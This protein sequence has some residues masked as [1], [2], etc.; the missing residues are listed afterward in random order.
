MDTYTI[1]SKTIFY[2]GVNLYENL[3]VQELRIELSKRGVN[4]T[5]KKKPQLETDLE[6]L[7]RGVTNV[8]ALLQNTPETPLDSL[9]LHN[10]EIS[11]TEPLHDI[12]GHLSNVADELLAQTTGNIKKKLSS[13]YESVLGKETLRCC[14]YRKAAILILLALDE[15][16]ADKKIIDLMRT[17]VE[18]TEILYSTNCKRSSQAVLRLHNVAFV[19]GKL[20]TEL[21]HTP[22]TMTRRKMFGRYFHSL[23]SHAPILYRLVCLRSMNAEMQ[24]RMF[25]QCKAITRATSSQH[26]DH[27]ITN[28][29]L[30]LQEESKNNVSSLKA[31]EG[32]I[33]KLAKA[34]GSKC[35]TIVPKEWLHQIPH[36]YQ[37]HLEKISD[38]LVDGPGSWWRELHGDIEFFDALTPGSSLPQHRMFHYRSTKLTNIESYLL[39]K[40]EACID[41]NVPLP[42]THI[43]TYTA[44][45]SLYSIET[46][47]DPQSPN[48]NNCQ[49]SP[50]RL[51]TPQPTE[52]T[53]PPT[54]HPTHS[55]CPSQAPTP[56]PTHSLSPSRAHTPLPTHS[57]CPSQ[58]PTPQP[59]CSLSPSQDPTPLPILSTCMRPCPTLA[60]ITSTDSSLQSSL[61]K[62]IAKVL[63]TDNE[64]TDFNRLRTQ[65]KACK[66]K[67]KSPSSS[68]LR[69]QYE[70]VSCSL[71]SKLV[72]A[73]KANTH[74]LNKW[75]EEFEAT[76]G[77][78]PQ[79]HNYPH[80]LRTASQIKELAQKI[81]LHEW[82]HTIIT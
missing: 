75:K 31:Q 54:P 64:V 28:I 14:D 46:A 39:M 24:E 27:I 73:Y 78:M 53:C 72:E 42:A 5:G 32:P 71:R 51:P 8:P 59:T 50:S 38:F 57:V 56:Q 19:H 70:A 63:P 21:F 1:S 61:A 15:L 47:E 33:T 74:T 62:S 3:K 10:Y 60:A 66:D 49:M 81:L 65:M 58:A 11:P 69:E 43:R 68:K 17:L 37:A 6:E 4:I 45:G 77:S 26:P 36:Q 9:Y 29:L 23:T 55:V 80:A 79:K 35:N 2:V 52:S 82:K 22:K 16:K 48:D 67:C 41:N 76:H 13:V 7:R 34:L 40:W 30:R 12:K 44:A 25:G 18:I 20:C